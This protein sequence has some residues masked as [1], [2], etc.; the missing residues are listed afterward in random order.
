VITEE[1]KKNPQCLL[2]VSWKVGVCYIAAWG[3]ANVQCG[4]GL[5]GGKEK[6]K[7]AKV[8]RGKEK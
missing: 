1:K 4:G 5:K 6:K 3:G 7:T 8:T 2:G